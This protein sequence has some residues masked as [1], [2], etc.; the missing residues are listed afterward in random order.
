MTD[1]ELNRR[2]SQLEMLVRRAETSRDPEVIRETS[3]LIKEVGSAFRGIRYPT[4]AEHNAAWDRFSSISKAY[5]EEREKRREEWKRRASVS[6]D[7][8]GEIV[9]MAQ[10]SWPHP[11]GFEDAVMMLIGITPVIFAAKFALH[12]LTFGLFPMIGAEL[13]RKDEL[14]RAS[15]NLREAW[16][17]FTENKSG[18]TREDKN[19]VFQVLNRVQGEVDKEWGKW[20]EEKQTEKEQNERQYRRCQER[21]QALIEEAETLLA[22][23]SSAESSSKAKSLQA[24]WK[25]VGY[26]GK[27]YERDLVSRFRSVMDEFFEA[28]KH[29]F[30]QKREQFQEREREFERRREE[31]E[32][33]IEEA[34]ELAI[35][36]TSRS[37]VE[38]AKQ[39]QGEWKEVGYAGRDHEETLWIRFRSAIDGFFQARKA[40][41]ER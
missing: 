15:R 6:E 19:E 39:L 26:A 9:R 23:V 37:N 2:I 25:T 33:L 35:D 40:H 14:Q 31:K 3:T 11:D 29:L 18:L 24:E 4:A 8:K 10:A 17:H 32:R 27:D 12:M 38:R 16:A 1:Q 22:D 7:L 28:R 36:V 34:E 13:S 20:K 41:Y 21:K 30:E 5:H